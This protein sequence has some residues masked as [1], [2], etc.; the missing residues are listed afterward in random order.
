MRHLPAPLARPILVRLLLVATAGNQHVFVGQRHPA[1]RAEGARP[2]SSL[3]RNRRRRQLRRGASIRV[4]RSSPLAEVV[5]GHRPR[6]TGVDDDGRER[7]LLGELLE[8]QMDLVIGDVGH[9]AHR[10][11]RVERHERAVETARFVAFAIRDLRAVAGE[12]EDD[13]V[14]GAGRGHERVE[15]GEDAVPRRLRIGEQGDVIGREAKAARRA[16]RASGAR[17]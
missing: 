9:V 6:V 12:M 15:R 14:V 4:D 11:H 17:R 5:A 8:P 13:D 16:P 1:A 10:P 3:L 7:G 2:P